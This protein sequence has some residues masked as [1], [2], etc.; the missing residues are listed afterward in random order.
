MAG[1]PGPDE[2]AL[3]GT[4]NATTE[5]AAQDAATQAN[6]MQNH[7]ILSHDSGHYLDGQPNYNAPISAA[8]DTNA[9]EPEVRDI[10]ADNAQAATTADVPGIP[11]PA[12][13]PIDPQALVSQPADERVLPEI[14][15]FNPPAT[16]GPTLADIDAQNRGH[17]AALDDVHAA[18]SGQL[19]QVNPAAPGDLPPLPPIP[20]LPPMPDFS[21]LPPVPGMPDPGAPVMGMVPPIA[22]SPLGATLPP[23]TVSGPT[24][25]DPAQF[26]IPGQ[27]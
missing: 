18:L 8:V 1:T 23:A 2:P 3:G 6:D 27:Q 10:F 25:S 11:A 26:K 14:P 13:P 17:Q 9:D 7:T 22:G 19:P 5:Q 21:T 15:G 16:E 24:A 20:Q 4:L 12:L